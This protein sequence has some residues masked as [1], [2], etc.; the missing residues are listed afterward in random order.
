MPKT[1]RDTKNF[2]TIGTND[3]LF[4]YLVKKIATDFMYEKD[5]Y[6]TCH[7]DFKDY[8]DSI[9]DYYARKLAEDGISFSKSKTNP[10]QWT[11]YKLVRDAY[12]W[13][14]QVVM[15]KTPVYRRFQ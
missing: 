1:F 5:R 3:E 11:S 10:I 15:V 2:G 9:G 8:A 14:V 4:A 6:P 7:A 13:I 12:Y